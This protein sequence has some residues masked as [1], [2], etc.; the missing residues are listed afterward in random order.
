[1]AGLALTS[2]AEYLS[3][4]IKPGTFIS[5]TCSFNDEKALTSFV[6]PVF[7]DVEICFSAA[8]P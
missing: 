1:M 6:F 4:A 7:R 8:D 2:R 3:Y 5:N